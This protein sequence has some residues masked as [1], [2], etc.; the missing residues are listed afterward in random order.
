MADSDGDDDLDDGFP[1]PVPGGDVPPPHVGA[2]GRRAQRSPVQAGGDGGGGRVGPATYPRFAAIY[3]WLAANV[4]FFRHAERLGRLLYR[5]GLISLVGYILWAPLA[6]LGFGGAVGGRRGP[7]PPPFDEWFEQNHG[8]V[9]PR[10][11]RGSCQQALSRSKTDAKF[12]LAYLHDSYEAGCAAFCDRV[13]SSALFQAFV[14]ENFVFWVGDLA[15]PEGAAVRRALRIQAAP[16]LVMLAHGDM[17][18]GQLRQGGGGGLHG[19]PVVQA[20]GTV[21]GARL[22]EEERLIGSLQ[23]QLQAFEPLL[24]AARAEQ[25]ERMM[26]RVMRD[27][28]EL[29]YQRSLAA[30]QEKDRLAREAEEAAQREEE[31][32]RREEDEA[33]ARALAEEQAA[34]DEQAAE[35]AR[36]RAKIARGQAVPPEPPAG[37]DATRLVIRLPDGRRLD[38]RFDK[39]TAL[40]VVIDYV[41]GEAPEEEEFDLVSAHPRMTYTKRMRPQTLSELGLHPGAQ[42]FTREAEEEEEEGGN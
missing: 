1:E 17:G 40:Q 32:K 19:E 18:G 16:A 9:H 13:L 2:G 26:D 34:R 4:P 5:T 27:E 33:R 20:L 23:A 38:R 30:D 21:Q 28:Q 36:I 25:H 37:A 15:T 24:V 11:F 41:E 3:G 10:F 14:D 6:L 8:N 7:P 39:S 31:A 42:L 22:L 12:L 29:E 35:E